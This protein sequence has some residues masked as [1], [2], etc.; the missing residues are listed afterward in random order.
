MDSVVDWLVYQLVFEEND[1]SVKHNKEV[2]KKAKE[3]EKEELEKVYQEVL[4]E[5]SKKD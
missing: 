2:I 4:K 1:D 3:M 5:I